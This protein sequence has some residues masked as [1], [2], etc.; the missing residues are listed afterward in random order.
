MPGLFSTLGAIRKKGGGLQP[1]TQA[2]PSDGLSAYQLW[3]AAGNTGTMAQY[4]A[5]L[6]GS[7][8]TSGWTPILGGELDG[9]RT[10]IK[11]VDWSGGT[12]TKPATSSR[13]LLPPPRYPG[14]LDR[15]W[16]QTPPPRRKRKSRLRR[17]RS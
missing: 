8:G 13:F 3:L 17:K 10:L 11:V 2:P 1:V 15:W 16:L 14:Q 9:T 6:N 12:G 5:S 4:L 7:N